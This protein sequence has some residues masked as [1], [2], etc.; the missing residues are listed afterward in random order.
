MLGQHREQKASRFF[1]LRRKKSAFLFALQKYTT[2]ITI[3]I[4]EEWL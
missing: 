3:S 1:F 4:L 2:F